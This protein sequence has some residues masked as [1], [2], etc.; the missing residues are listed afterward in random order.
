MG[1]AYDALESDEI[2]P[3]LLRLSPGE[4]EVEAPVQTTVRDVAEATGLTEKE[5]REALREVRRSRLSEELRT[6]EEP[7][8]RVERPGSGP[9][10]DVADYLA[11]ERTLN[12]LLDRMP[13]ASPSPQAPK[14]ADKEHWITYAILVP[15]ATALA[16]F[17]I[18][19]IFLT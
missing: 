7:L 4:P 3:L 14:A 17:L 12:T 6:L 9:R 19:A 8:F 2:E 11:R 5:I 10:S 15:L 1:K 13:P 16:Y 18:R